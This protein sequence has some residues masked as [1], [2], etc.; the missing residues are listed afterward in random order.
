MPAYNSSNGNTLPYI[1]DNPGAFRP[2]LWEK[3]AD[4][5]TLLR[6]MFDMPKV[7]LTVDKT[8]QPDTPRVRVCLLYTSPSP[9]DRQK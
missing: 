1:Y 6:S 5:V 7:E 3:D 2:Y 4:R 9:R 8:P